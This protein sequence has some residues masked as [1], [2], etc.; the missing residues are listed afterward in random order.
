MVVRRP[1]RTSAFLS[2]TSR[3]RTGK[4]RSFLMLDAEPAASYGYL[5]KSYLDLACSGSTRRSARAYR[6]A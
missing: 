3:S 2:A 5:L 4:T 1:T 6:L